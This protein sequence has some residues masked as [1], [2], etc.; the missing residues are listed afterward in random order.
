MRTRAETELG[1]N[2]DIR[3]FHDV[4]VGNG[5]LPIT[6]LEEIVA[7]WIAAQQASAEE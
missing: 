7:E 5:S 2:F 4:V 3:D 6:V 1:E